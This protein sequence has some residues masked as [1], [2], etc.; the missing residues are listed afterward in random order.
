MIGGRLY[1]EYAQNWPSRVHAKYRASSKQLILHFL[2]FLLLGTTV[3]LLI[4]ASQRLLPTLIGGGFALVAFY[5]LAKEI[6][7]NFPLEE[8]RNRSIFEEHKQRGHDRRNP[9]AD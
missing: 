8:Q 7:R 3:G 2:F 9:L 4:Y 5:L 1:R 6:M